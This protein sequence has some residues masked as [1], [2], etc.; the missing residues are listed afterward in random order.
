MI[1]F[2]RNF[3]SRQSIPS[4]CPLCL[5]SAH[6]SQVCHPCWQDLYASVQ[7]NT[8]RCQYC[9]ASLVN[10]QANKH[11]RPESALSS[12]PKAPIC[13]DCH[14]HRLALDKIYFGFDY[15]LPIDSLILRFKNARQQSLS[16]ALANLVY[17]RLVQDKEIDFRQLSS[18]PLFIPIPSSHAALKRRGYNPAAEFAKSLAKKFQAPLALNVLHRQDS[19]N[20]QKSLSRQARLVASAQSY[21]CAYRLDY[22][23]V[24]LVDD[25]MTS[26]STLDSAAKAL[27]AAGV[28]RVEAIVIARARHRY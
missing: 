4:V 24:I 28:Q 18:P 26:G 22:P 13:Q 1:N 21:Y 12:S 19:Q 8:Q 3:F 23:H 20:Q 16:H 11:L 2:I 9:Q 6:G 15:E 25:I 14:E 27:F 10:S 5:G 17:Q 7:H